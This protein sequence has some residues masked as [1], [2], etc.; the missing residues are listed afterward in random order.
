MPKK[1]NW[2]NRWRKRNEYDYSSPLAIEGENFVASKRTY[3]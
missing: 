3:N 2:R 1:T